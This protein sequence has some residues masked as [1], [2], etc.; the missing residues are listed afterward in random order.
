LLNC[1]PTASLYFVTFVRTPKNP[2]LKAQIFKHLP[3]QLNDIKEQ[4]LTFGAPRNATFCWRVDKQEAANLPVESCSSA[5]DEDDEALP[6]FIY[7][8]CFVERVL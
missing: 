6:A 4:T 7:C 8:I 1:K 3:K 5:P 2:A